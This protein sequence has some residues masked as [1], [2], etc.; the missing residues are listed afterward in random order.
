MDSFLLENAPARGYYLAYYQNALVFEPYEITDGR[1]LF[2]GCEAFRGQLPRECHLFDE[3]TECRIVFR[4]HP[5]G[6]VR[7]VLTRGQELETDPDLLYEEEV[8]VKPEYASGGRR[9]KTLKIMNRYR[10]SEYDTLTLENYRISA[11]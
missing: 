3:D 9:P 7:L 1:L 6:P 5:G 11:E 4:S 2:E 8:L 10:Y